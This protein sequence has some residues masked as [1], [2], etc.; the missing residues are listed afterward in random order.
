MIASIVFFIVLVDGVATGS[1]NALVTDFDCRPGMKH[2]G[3]CQQLISGST[4][5][6]ALCSYKGVGDFIVNNFS[7]GPVDWLWPSTAPS[8]AVVSESW[9]CVDDGAAFCDTTGNFRDH[10]GRVAREGRDGLGT[11]LIRPAGNGGPIDDCGADGFTQAIGTVVTTVTDYTRSERCAAVLVTVPPP[12]ETVWYDGK[13][14]F[15]PSS[16]SAAPPILG[17]MLLALI[18]AHPT[19]T[20]RMIQRI[21]VRA[22]KPVTVTG[23]RGRGWWLNRV[24]D[25][26][27]HRNFGFGEVSPSR[28]EIEARRELS[29]SRAPVAWSTLDT[30]DL[31]EVEWVR[32]RLGI[33]PAV[34]RGGVTVEISSP[35]GTIIEILGKRPLDFSR[36][37]FEG[38]FVTPLF[39]GEPGRGK[40]TVSCTG[41]VIL[42]TE[43]TCHGIR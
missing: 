7:M 11:V 6:N 18:R 43:G 5:A 26:W 31:S 28:L 41:G 35:S 4:G 38:E 10:R 14:G 20:L 25:R 8:Y 39:W 40:W 24:T 21:L 32:V 16:S 29:T 2:C 1:P 17:N 19:L 12:N 42:T 9:G 22:A 30:C 3:V 37:E 33:A 23:W 13:C 15:I 27:T 36:D 34:F